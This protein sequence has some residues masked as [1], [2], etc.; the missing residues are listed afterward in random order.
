MDKEIGRVKKNDTTDIV[1]KV[2][3]FGGVPGVT[4]REFI[5][6]ERYTGFTKAGTRITSDNFQ[7][8]K[9][10]INS[11][12]LKEDDTESEQQED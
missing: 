10:M 8:F 3:D 9:D 1:I 5:S 11:I 6:S 4:I 7:K 12:E 2:D